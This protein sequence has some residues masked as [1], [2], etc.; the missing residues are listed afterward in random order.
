MVAFGSLKLDDQIVVPFKG[1]GRMTFTLDDKT[2]WAIEGGGEQARFRMHR[3]GVLA[4]SMLI[5][6]EPTRGAF[7]LSF[8]LG[9][10]PSPKEDR[11]LGD[12]LTF[13]SLGKPCR[14]NKEPTR[15]LRTLKSGHALMQRFYTMPSG[16]TLLA[17]RFTPKS[18]TP[19]ISYF[20]LQ[21]LV[22][23]EIQLL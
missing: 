20:Q 2:V 5:H 21:P 16:R 18:G 17:E 6:T 10:T 13:T 4:P 14:V 9:V 1:E 23:D 12:V 3:D 22:E 7:A 15:Y 19:L 8:A 11:E